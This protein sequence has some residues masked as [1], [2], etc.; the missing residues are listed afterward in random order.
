MGGEVKGINGQQLRKFVIRPALDQLGLWSQE[1]EDLVFGTACQESGCGHY[2]HQLGNGPA[3]GIFQMEPRSYTDL[4]VW[5]SQVRRKEWDRIWT[6][7]G[8]IGRSGDW[9]PADQMI[10]DLKYAAMMCRMFYLRKPG[11]IPVTLAGQAAYWKRFYNTSLG[12]GTVE[13]YI[14]NYQK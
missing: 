8:Q 14:R 4:C 2:L 3:V 6:H 12:K 5:I 11:A 7:T 9:P 1:A 13:E 10:W